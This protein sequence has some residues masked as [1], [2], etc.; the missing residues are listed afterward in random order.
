MYT[1]VLNL[2]IFEGIR[3]ARAMRFNKFA[4]CVKQVEVI[5]N[6]VGDNAAHLDF[7]PERPLIVVPSLLEGAVAPHRGAPSAFWITAI[8]RGAETRCL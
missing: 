8:R 3:A 6:I 4:R 5:Y 2:K 7:Q 1:R